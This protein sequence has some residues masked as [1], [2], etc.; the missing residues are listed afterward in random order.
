[1]DA[2]MTAQPDFKAARPARLDPTF[3]TP[4]AAFWSLP[5]AEAFARVG[6]SPSGLSSREADL[7]LKRFGAN[8]ARPAAR[9]GLLRRIIGRLTQPLVALLL[10]AGFVS[11]GVGDFA[12]SAIIATVV[13]LSIALEIWQEHKADVAAEALRRSVALQANVRRDGAL[14]SIPVARIV[15]GDMVELRPGDIAPADGWVIESNSLRVDEAALTGE[16]YPVEKRP[17]PSGAMTMAEAYDALFAGSSAVSGSGLLLVAATGAD[18][19]FGRMALSLGADAPRTAFERGLNDLGR[20]ILKLTIFLCLFVLLAQI[21]LHRPIMEAFLFALALAVGMTPELLPMVTTVTLSRGAVRMAE[22]RVVCKTL[23]A[24]HDLGAMD[25]LCTDKTG[26]LTE[27]KVALAAAVDPD[28][29]PSADVLSLAAANARPPAGGGGVLDQAIL[30]AGPVSHGWSVVS[31]APFDFVRRRSS[32]L[33]EKNGARLIIVKGAPEA[34]L[35]ACR[36]VSRS[37]GPRALDD[38]ERSRVAAE[39]DASA[40]K[41]LRCLAVATRAPETGRAISPA[42]ERDLVLQGLCFFADPVKATAPAAAARLKALGVRIKILSGDAPAVVARVAAEIGLPRLQVLTGDQVAEL[43]EA[44]LAVRVRAVDLFARL[45]PDQKVRVVRALSRAGHT[46]GFLGDGINDAPAIRAADAGISVESATDVARAAADL[47][48]LE[49]DLGVLADGVA[50]GRRTHANI[51]K[52]IRMATSSNFGNMISMAV[53]S[54]ALPFLPLAPVQ[55]LL[56]NLLYDVSEAGIPFD[57]V[58]AEE[59]RAPHGWDIGRIYRFMLVMGPLSSA[60]DLAAF[61]T[62]RLAFDA[63]VAAFQTAWFVESMITQILV[64]FV[65]RTARPFWT[66]RPHR[67]LVAASLGALGCAIAVALSPLG[68]PFGF[69]SPGSSVLAAMLAISLCYLAA[70]EIVKRFAMQAPKAAPRRR[71]RRA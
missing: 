63:P 21:V 22:R 1:M 49:S 9:T 44:A 31:E 29:R 33:A 71:L 57:D 46:V 32:V 23:S 36:A 52:Y 18:T 43:S 7:R 11:G 30:S 15:P 48:M 70:A 53:A 38:A 61:A 27:A 28:G 50:E 39:V 17:G 35:A 14:V 40:A 26:T 56:N 3:R 20:L 55:V 60:F 66:P 47:I 10:I 34:V 65:I 5:S 6:S 45:A 59:A 24:I 68:A 8:V 54:V 62:L 16:A 12:S 64:V 2:A 67:L 13:G 42:D 19:A 4:D 25:V 51:L 37:D 58:D 41:G 69:V